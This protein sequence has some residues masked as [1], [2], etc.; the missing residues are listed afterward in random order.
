MNISATLSAV[1]LPAVLMGL[2]TIVFLILERVRPGRELPRS[3]R[4]Y[5]RAIAINLVQLGITFTTARLWIRIFGTHSFFTL[6]HW[7]M[8]LAE[9][10]VAWLVGTLV[11]YWWHRLRH[12]NG[13]W[14]AFHQIHHSPSRIEIMTSFYKHPI[15]IF[16][17]A[18]LSAVILYP[19][20]GCSLPAAFWYNFFAGTGEYFYHAN[21]KSP[22][23]LRYLI[24]TPELHSIH[25][26]FNVHNF[27]F[28]DL[29]IWD[30][31]FGTYKDTTA[32]V[33][34]CGFPKGAESRLA[35]M[36]M[37]K[38]VYADGAS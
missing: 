1:S 5:L 17:D 19:L 3:K 23:W 24:Q 8:S 27:N 20:L 38:D 25:H 18:A 7:H 15:E 26:Q 22:A 9:G 29:P 11:F 13:W 14:L 4:W 31:L 21:V 2:S 36:L 32:F 6:S 16:C 30:R 34:R 12:E 28:S 10:F 33:A 37:F 35:D